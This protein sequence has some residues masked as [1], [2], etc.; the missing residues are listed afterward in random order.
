MRKRL[1]IVLL[2]LGGLLL[3]WGITSYFRAEGQLGAI[4]LGAILFLAGMVRYRKGGKD[5][6]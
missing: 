3:A 1:A 4:A 2:V 6:G 5:K